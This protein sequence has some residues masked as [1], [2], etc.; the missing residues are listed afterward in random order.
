MTVLCV[1]E[2]EVPIGLK[3]HERPIGL[4]MP[5]IR[6]L[7]SPR[8]RCGQ[9]WQHL[10][11]KAIWTRLPPELVNIRAYKPVEGTSGGS[12]EKYY[13]WCYCTL[14]DHIHIR[15]CHEGYDWA[16]RYRQ[17]ASWKRKEL[18]F[19]NGGRDWTMIN[20]SSVLFI[21]P[22]FSPSLWSDTNLAVIFFSG[23][24]RCPSFLGRSKPNGRV[25]AGF[26]TQAVWPCSRPTRMITWSG[27]G[28]LLLIMIITTKTDAQSMHFWTASN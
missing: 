17:T 7:N 24:L 8:N 3:C 10:H 28:K 13:R 23:G 18:Y 27:T 21:F 19:L 5:N 6:K 12:T 15:R 26:R 1:N 11:L 16:Q 14:E 9:P 4:W 22:I 20:N 25:K 2:V